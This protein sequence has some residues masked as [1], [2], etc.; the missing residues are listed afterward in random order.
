MTDQPLVIRPFLAD[1]WPRYRDLR[2]HAL[3]ESPDAFGSTF[4]LECVRT[5]DEWADRLTRAATSPGDLPLVA[6]CDGEP[7][8]LAWVRIEEATP[9]LAHLYQMWVSPAH[10]RRGVGRALLDTAAAWARAMGAHE[11]ELDVTCT[12]EGALRLYEGGGFVLYGESRPL[13][14]GATLRAQA[15]RRRLRPE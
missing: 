3:E 2:L 11:L 12:N 15:M 13:R 4:A 6:E 14:P 9:E 7:A 1:E 5:D 8:G 10:R